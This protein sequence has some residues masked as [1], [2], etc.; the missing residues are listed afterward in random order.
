MADFQEHLAE[1]EQRGV[2]IIAASTDPPEKARETITEYKITFP[3]ACDIDPALIGE[4]TGAYY[5]LER[6]FVNGTGFIIGPDSTLSGAVYSTNPIGRY[7]AAECVG[8]ISHLT[9][10]G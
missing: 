3:V 6:G 10:K 7:T 1:F 2:A 8:Y 5:D 4:K 9:R